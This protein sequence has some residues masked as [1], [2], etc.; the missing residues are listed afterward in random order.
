M[1]RVCNLC[2][3]LVAII[4]TSIWPVSFSST[5][6]EVSSTAIDP[7]KEMAGFLL[8]N[9]VS[10]GTTRKRKRKERGK[11][12]KKQSYKD[13]DEMEMIDERDIDEKSFDF[14]GYTLGEITKVLVNLASS[15]GALKSLDGMTHQF[16]NTLRD[17]S[18]LNARY[19]KFVEKQ[20][21]TDYE[22][23]EEN[24]MK[25]KSKGK[26][27][28]ETKEAAKVLEYV[29]TV[30]RALQATEILTACSEKSD[31]AR[32]ECLRDAGLVELRRVPLMR[33]KL[34]YSLSIM[35]PLKQYNK[36]MKDRMEKGLQSH[37]NLNKSNITA[38]STATATDSTIH[39]VGGKKKSKS[40]KHNRNNKTSKE[41][42]SN[43]ENSNAEKA[44][45]E[46]DDAD[47]DDIYDE[48]FNMGELIVGIVDE[49]NLEDDV[50]QVLRVMSQPVETISLKSV[51]LMQEDVSIQPTLLQL[52]TDVVENLRDY[53]L[54]INKESPQLTEIEKSANKTEDDE[55]HDV[56]TS[57]TSTSPPTQLPSPPPPLINSL[58]DPLPRSVR[59]LGHSAGGATAAYAAMILDG[60]LN[61]TDSLLKGT[62]NFWGLYHKKVRCI[63]LGPPP[64]LSRAVVPRFVS[65][66]I[67]GD[68]VVPR[69]SPT[70]LPALK[71]VHYRHSKR[72]LQGVPSDG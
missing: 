26:S 70:L 7:L 16:R 45:S 13:D 56:L 23:D 17:A 59:F 42:D 29:T 49:G 15:Q 5:F 33:N 58:G 28:A 27:K 47:D 8:R 35:M 22:D 39:E 54:P 69:A 62:N 50:A 37:V 14:S 20:Q 19:K 68:D 3:I 10:T 2:I 40:K 32:T 51:G 24:G 4:L 18:S 41:K 44:L 6:P 36:L 25:G 72:V 57:Y 63:A 46:S 43:Q 64:C 52:A 71:N 11:N 31:A 55:S 21:G 67:C 61:S 12:G 1:L 30:E 65:S 66:I 60:A 48:R 53:I 38:T 34:R 9:S